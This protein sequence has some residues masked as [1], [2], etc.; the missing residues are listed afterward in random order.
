MLRFLLLHHLHKDLDWCNG[1]VALAYG[2]RGRGFK[3]AAGGKIGTRITVPRP[4]STQ[5]INEYLLFRGWRSYGREN[6]VL[7]SFNI[8]IQQI[9]TTVQTCCRFSTNV[10]QIQKQICYWS[11]WTEP[12]RRWCFNT[13]HCVRPTKYLR[14]QIADVW[15]LSL[16]TFQNFN[17]SVALSKHSLNLLFLH[18]NKKRG[19]RLHV[20]AGNLST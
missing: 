12:P 10:F 8:L 9:F 14:P 13:F 20:M 2:G 3:S 17:I 5:P 18:V 4:G 19:K 15:V 7:N 6:L 1:Y 16:E 11:Q